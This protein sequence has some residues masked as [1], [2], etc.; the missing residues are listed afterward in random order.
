VVERKPS[1][2]VVAAADRLQRTVLSS[3]G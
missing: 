2:R 3:A 1:R